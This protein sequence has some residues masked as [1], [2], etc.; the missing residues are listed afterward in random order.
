MPAKLTGYRKVINKC[1]RVGWTSYPKYEDNIDYDKLYEMIKHKDSKIKIGITH[2]PKSWK[3]YYELI[4]K[5]KNFKRGVFL[6]KLIFIHGDLVGN[7]IFERYK[8]KQSKTNSFEYKNQKYGMTKQQYDEYNK[9]RAIT[10]DNMIKKYGEKIGTEKYKKYCDR[11]AYTNSAPY[12]GTEKYKEVNRK[13]SHTIQ[14][15]IERYGEEQGKN[16]LLEFYGKF[17]Y[18]KGFSKISQEC[19]KLVES[20]LTEEEKEKTY[21]ATKNKEYC[22]LVEDRIFLYDFV[23][24]NLNLC[25]E[26]HGDHYHGNPKI[27][28]PDDVLRGRGCSET[29]VKDKWKED[30]FKINSLKNMRNYDTIVIWDR[31]WREDSGDVLTKVESFIKN[32]RDKNIMEITY[33]S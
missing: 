17:T 20:I 23:C 3:E 16:K 5:Y 11:Q 6:E 9:S 22:L 2:S 12:L 10:L 25:I 18:N 4:L 15:Y 26:Y 1:N 33:G 7:E 27:Y 31:D 29:K 30:L 24:I 21:Y 8:E 13:K 19:F 14:T 32:K 28:H